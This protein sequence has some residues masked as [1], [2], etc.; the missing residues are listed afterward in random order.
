MYKRQVVSLIHHGGKGQTLIAAGEFIK[1]IAYIA[2]Y[3]SRRIVGLF[4]ES[5]HYSRITVYAGI[6]GI[7]IVRYENIRHIAEMYISYTLDIEA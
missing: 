1:F 5:K 7:A 6:Y 2:R 4:G 3:G